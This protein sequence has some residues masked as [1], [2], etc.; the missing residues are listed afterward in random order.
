MEEF[1]EV[2]R[3]VDNGESTQHLYDELA[4][5]GGVIINW[6][7]SIQQRYDERFFQDISESYPQE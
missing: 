3:A 4:D 5:A 1:G 7:R 2:A 6:M